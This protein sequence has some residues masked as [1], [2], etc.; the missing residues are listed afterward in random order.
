MGAR[1]VPFFLGPKNGHALGTV[2]FPVDFA[3]P[4]RASTRKSV[5]GYNLHHENRRSGQGDNMATEVA[6]PTKEMITK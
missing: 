6:Q 3:F 5:Q 1:L 2:F 4:A